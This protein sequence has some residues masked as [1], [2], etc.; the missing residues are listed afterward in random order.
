MGGFRS[1]PEEGEEGRRGQV[2]AFPA[3]RK[4][5]ARRNGVLLRV[6]GDCRGE[7][8]PG[9]WRA[10]H[11]SGAGGEELSAEDAGEL[12]EEA[13]SGEEGGEGW[14][15]AGDVGAA[16]VFEEGGSVEPIL[17]VEEGVVVAEGV[18]IEDDELSVFADVVAPVDFVVFADTAEF[19]PVAVVVGDAVD[20][21]AVVEGNETGCGGNGGAEAGVGV[22]KGEE[23]ADHPVGEV[24]IEPNG[25]GARRGPFGVGEGEE[26]FSEV[27]EDVEE[28][29][30]A[31]AVVG[32]GGGDEGEGGVG[33]VGGVG[34]GE[35][36]V[37]VGGDE[38]V[39]VDFEVEGT[40]VAADAFVLEVG[41]V[42]ALAPGAG[43]D[44]PGDV[45]VAAEKGVD[46]AEV[47]AADAVEEEG[48]VV[49]APDGAA[50]EEAIHAEA[51]AVQP[52]AGQNH[53]DF[54]HRGRA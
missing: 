19:L 26:L 17:L 15:G 29:P 51:E 49:E 45:G 36:E 9:R 23:L 12:G 27:G 6:G 25:A 40:G 48:D 7:K 8:V 1:R 10:G 38:D 37:P 18:G 2:S 47:A 11:P 50:G 28:A 31:E 14:E 16:E 54:F 3:Q 5:E 44:V 52:V 32:D 35:A 30:S 42:P 22:F 13:E 46:V 24:G 43:D 21:E 4:E 39:F 53:E 20:A 34:F 41:D 33:A